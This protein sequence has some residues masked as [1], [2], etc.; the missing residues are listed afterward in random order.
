MIFAPIP[1]PITAIFLKLTLH[2]YNSDKQVSYNFMFIHE[3]A[4]VDDLN[5]IGDDTK[6]G[7]ILTS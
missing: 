5:S 4:I 3:T 7:T 6:F 2:Y 1:K